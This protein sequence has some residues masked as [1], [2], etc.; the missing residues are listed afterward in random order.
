M[1]DIINETFTGADDTNIDGFNSWVASSTSLK[2]K[3]NKA[4]VTANGAV[5]AYKS[6]TG[7][8]KEGTF[9]FFADRYQPGSDTGERHVNYYIL[10][11][12]SIATEA[13]FRTNGISIYIERSD[14]NDTSTRLFVYDGSTI[15][16]TTSNAS[17]DVDS[18]IGTDV[19]LTIEADGSGSCVFFQDPTTH[20]LTWAA[21]TWVKGDGDYHGFSLL[22]NVTDGTSSKTWHAVDDFIVSTPGGGGGV[23]KPNFLGFSRI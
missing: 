22:S 11:S 5:W 15:V 23:T 8:N 4:A 12:T 19:L 10:A 17:F 18:D 6:A 20:T 9:S 13:D 16:A 21:R 3:S 14:R 2:I 1:A 7:F